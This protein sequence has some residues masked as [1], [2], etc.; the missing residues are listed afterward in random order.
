MARK[1]KKIDLDESDELMEEKNEIILG[2]RKTIKLL[3]EGKIKKVIIAK[4]FDK[5]L[6]NELL[7]LGKMCSAEIIVSK[8]N[9]REIAE[10]LK[11]PFLIGCIGV[12]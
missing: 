11:K 6:K 2:V 1:K 9:R 10:K 12:K 3:K 5:D 7:E 8:R 4:D